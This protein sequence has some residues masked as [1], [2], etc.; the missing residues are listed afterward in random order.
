M[1]LANQTVAKFIEGKRLGKHKFPFVYR[2]HDEPDTEKLNTFAMN[3]ADFGHTI[4]TDNKKKLPFELNRFF[5]EIE[6]SPEQHSLES[7]AIRSM[8]K[9]VYSTDNI[10]HY[11]LGF[12]HYSHFT[13]PIRRYPDMMVHRQLNHYINKRKTTWEN[14]AELEERSEHCSNMERRAVEAERESIKYFQVV[15]MQDKVGEEF[16]GIVTGVTSWGFFVEISDVH[17]EGL[18]RLNT[19]TDDNYAFDEQK[20]Q[21][22]GFNTGKTFKL[23]SKV[24]VRVEEVSVEKRQMDLSFILN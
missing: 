3:A 9:A 2:I 24:K 20:K 5:K 12:E 1:L 22:V 14:K 4:H 23:G 16:T 19:L 6:G 15:Y 17:T 7:L 10:G 13:S 18:V 11:G 21:I 8:A